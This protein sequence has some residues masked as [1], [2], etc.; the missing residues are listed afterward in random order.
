MTVIMQPRI[1]NGTSYDMP[2]VNGMDRCQINTRL[3]YINEELNK[4]KMK[5]AA[6]VSARDE[7]DRHAELQESENLFDEMFGG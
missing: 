6:L 5:Q 4:I 7:L 3:H 2:T 1:I